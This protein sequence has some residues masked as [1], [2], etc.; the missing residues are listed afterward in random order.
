LIIDRL[1]HAKS[2]INDEPDEA[3]RICN[4]VL[5]E[6]FND[7]DAQM[8]LF[9]AAYIMLQAERYGLAYHL[10]QRCAQ[11]RPDMSEIWSNM[12]MCLEEHDPEKAKGLFEKAYRLN[13]KN[14]QALANHGLMCLQTAE[15]EKCIKLSAQALEI[16]PALVPAAHNKALAQLMLRDWSGWKGYANTLGVKHR[17]ARDYGKPD[18]N[19]ELGTVLVYGEQGVGDEIMFASCLPDLMKTNKVI[20]DCDKRLEGLFKRSFDC[21]VYG[22][23]FRTQSRAADQAFDYQCAIG[24]LPSFYRLTDESFP[25][26]KYLKTDPERSL[27][28]RALF[29]T[30]KGDKVGIAWR[31]GLRNTGEKARSLELE[32]FEPILDAENT[33]ISLEYKDVSAEDLSK[34]NLK[35]YTRA[36]KGGGDIDDLAALIGQL[37]YVVTCCTTVVYVAGALGVPCYILVPSKPGYRYHLT[38][39]L[40]WY[41]STNIIRQRSGESW[42]STTARAREIIKQDRN[43]QNDDCVQ[44]K[45]AELKAVAR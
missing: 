22:D 18:W 4:E 44:K 27:Q 42:K 16:D 43:V 1:L 38:G 5:N 20:F 9:M 12:G 40:P 36:T 39:E 37:D 8:A 21:E 17:E 45:Q 26:K 10:Y 35:S 7:Q 3:L 41:D 29:D 23:R 11:L 15:P 19:G 33:F 24:Q 30:F 32:D 34:Y 25:G 31:G 14:A 2:I 6:S 28:W 13:N